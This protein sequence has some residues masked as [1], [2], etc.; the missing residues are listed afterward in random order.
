MRELA[1]PPGS[2]VP[3][4]TEYFKEMAYEDMRKVLATEEGKRLIAELI[5]SFGWADVNPQ[6]FFNAR[7]NYLNGMQAAG[8]KMAQIARAARPDL[9]GGIF[10][11]HDSM[12]AELEVRRKA[13]NGRP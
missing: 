10:K 11:I 6:A 13:N 9:F 1:P 5:F 3:P 12:V 4:T 2:F 8:A 7:D